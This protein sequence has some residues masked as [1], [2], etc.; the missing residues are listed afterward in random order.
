MEIG[1]IL[2][3][4]IVKDVSLQNPKDHAVAIP[5]VI[6]LLSGMRDDQLESRLRDFSVLYL[7][8]SG[9]KLIIKLTRHLKFG[10]LLKS[11]QLVPMFYSIEL[12]VSQRSIADANIDRFTHVAHTLGQTKMIS[13]EIKFSNFNLEM[14]FRVDR[15]HQLLYHWGNKRIPYQEMLDEFVSWNKNRVN[16]FVLL[17]CSFDLSFH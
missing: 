12:T 1:L 7:E 5:K 14:T 13:L 9:D 10:D 8:R 3:I 16:S 2:L 15:N 11:L 4:L 6:G 17:I